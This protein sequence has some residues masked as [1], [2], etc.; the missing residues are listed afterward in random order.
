MPELLAKEVAVLLQLV[1]ALAYGVTSVG[2]GAHEAGD[3][4]VPAGAVGADAAED[5]FRLERQFRVAEQAVGDLGELVRCHHPTA[6]PRPEA[7]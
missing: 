6:D 3:R 4:H 2:S 7:A 5:P 1:Q